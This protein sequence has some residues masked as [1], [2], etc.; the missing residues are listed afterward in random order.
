MTGHK[1][2]NTPLQ[3]LSGNYRSANAVA[4][5]KR[6]LLACPRFTDRDLLAEYAYRDALALADLVREEDPNVVFGALAHYTPDQLSVLAVA[7][8]AMVPT[9]RTPADLLGWLNN[10]EVA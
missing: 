7:L 8:A 5:R 6:C 4:A 3:A 1:P 2:P 9:D 10:T